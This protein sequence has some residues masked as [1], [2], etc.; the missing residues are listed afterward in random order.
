VVINDIENGDPRS[1]TPIIMNR[2]DDIVDDVHAT[3]KSTVKKFTYEH[4]IHY[5]NKFR[6]IFD[7]TNLEFYVF[8]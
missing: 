6:N 2:D 4:S 5:A 3:V 8:V 1:F 7:N